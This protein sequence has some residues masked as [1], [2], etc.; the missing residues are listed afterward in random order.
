MEDMS[1]FRRNEL[2]IISGGNTGRKVKE[3]ESKLSSSAGDDGAKP[4][5]GKFICLVLY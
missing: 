3:I 4:E 5:K 1:S 2:E